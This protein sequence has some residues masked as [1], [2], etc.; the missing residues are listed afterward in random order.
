[1]TKQKNDP[2][3]HFLKNNFDLAL[4]DDFELSP[5]FKS[6]FDA[7]E[8]TDKNL[9]ITG[10]AGTGKT[11]LLKYFRQNTKK[12]FVVLAPTGIAAINSHGQ[13]IHSFFRFPPKFI[14]K[15]HI[16]KVWNA[17]HIFDSLD[18]LIVDEASMM[19]ADL[20]D[21]IDQALRINKDHPRKPFG[22][23][24][25]VLFGDLF[26]L[27]PIVDRDMREFYD[28]K[29]ETPY[30][31]SAKV[32]KE[33]KFHRINLRK[34]YRQKDQAFK[35]ILNKIRNRSAALAEMELLNS[36][37][38]PALCETAHD[39]ITLTPT[40]AAANAINEARLEK[41]KDKEFVYDAVVKGEFDEKSYPTETRLRL[42]KGAQVLM[43]RNDTE[44]RWVNGSIGEVV[45]LDEDSIEVRIG[46]ETHAV[47][48]VT[49]EKIR[50][51]YDEDQDAIV[52]DVIG[53]FEQYPIKLAWAITIHK[54]QGLTF[55]KLIID[56]DHGAFTH[57]Q[58]YVAISRC[59]SLEGVILKRPVKHRDIIFDDRIQQ[60]EEY[61]PELRAKK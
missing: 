9:Y 1:M 29:Y 37:V 34:I 45:D 21:G 10:E 56:L 38:D 18:L 27:P 41:L 40:N 44:K 8:R 49:W 39:C 55:D 2:G 3:V 20:M 50:Y 42:R 48:A 22:G 35:D 15:D 12:K 61:F 43:I 5:E 16:R 28:Q 24:Q 6:G 60:I 52:E 51:R 47:E 30:F 59:R 4:P 25:V 32:F 58:V 36:R 19:R 7:I 23:V 17:G 31:F 11:T 54:S 57:G 33:V 46:E 13:T 14:Q 26:Q 53:S